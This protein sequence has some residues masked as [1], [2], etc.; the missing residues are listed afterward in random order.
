MQL[1]GATIKQKPH[2]SDMHITNDKANHFSYNSF[3]ILI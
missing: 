2:L 3:I 1:K